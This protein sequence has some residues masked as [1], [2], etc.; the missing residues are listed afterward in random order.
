MKIVSPFKWLFPRAQ[1]IYKGVYG[2]SFLHQLSRPAFYYNTTTHSSFINPERSLDQT[3]LN[4]SDAPLQLQLDAKRDEKN[5]RMYSGNKPSVT[6]ILDATRPKSDLYALLNWRQGLIKKLG[7]QGYIDKVSKI[8]K[9]GTTFHQ[10]I[11]EYLLTGSQPIVHESNGGHWQSIKHV[12]SN[13]DQVIALESAVTHPQLEYAG[14]L[15]GIISYKGQQCLVDWKTSEKKRVKLK[16]CFSYPHQ[17]VAYAGAVNHDPHYDPIQVEQGLL[18]LA[19]QDGSPAETIW[20]GPDTCEYYWLEWQQRLKLYHQTIKPNR[21]VRI[22]D[23]A[24]YVNGVGSNR[25]PVEPHQGT[26]EAVEPCKN[27]NLAEW[28]ESVIDVLETDPSTFEFEDNY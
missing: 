15:D 8:R 3:Y 25:I 14:T 7:E 18:V 20:L 12:I 4:T 11:K 16:D 1:Q 22:Q 6:T 24:H 2:T 10:V 27:T 19:Y 9:R 23:L 5:G 21:G 17:I 13:I 28:S 26:L